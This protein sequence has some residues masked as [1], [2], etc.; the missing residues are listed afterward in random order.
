[1]EKTLTCTL[2]NVA[3]HEDLTER[4]CGCITEV[5]LMG[6]PLTNGHCEVG[7]WHIREH[8]GSLEVKC[9]HWGL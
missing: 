5:N 7:N 1:M 3:L 8:K 2:S 6:G 9:H 4:H